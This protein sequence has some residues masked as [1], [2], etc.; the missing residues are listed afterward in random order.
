MAQVWVYFGALDLTC[1]EETDTRQLKEGKTEI[2]LM[3]IICK[4]GC[5][6]TDSHKKMKSSWGRREVYLS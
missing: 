2:I 3:N 6:K 4:V 5:E 1:M